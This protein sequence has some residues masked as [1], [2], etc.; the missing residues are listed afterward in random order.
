MSP[1]EVPVGAN[2]YDWEWLSP[3]RRHD[4]KLVHHVDLLPDWPGQPS[5]KEFFCQDRNGNVK[6]IIR[7][8][9]DAA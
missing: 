6:G 2:P 1:D 4:L 5:I 3:S 8:I 7:L 9:S